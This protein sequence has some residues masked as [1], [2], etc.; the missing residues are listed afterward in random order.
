MKIEP[1]ELLPIGN[2]VQ[3]I[4]CTDLDESDAKDKEVLEAFFEDKVNIKVI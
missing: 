4:K 2:D 3:I 1:S